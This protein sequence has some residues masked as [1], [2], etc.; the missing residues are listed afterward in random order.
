MKGDNSV[1]GKVR[2]VAEQKFSGIG[3]AVAVAALVATHFTLNNT[4]N[5]ITAM[6]YR[7]AVSLMQQSHI[8]LHVCTL[9]QGIKICPVGL[10]WNKTNAYYQ[11]SIP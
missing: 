11:M 4:Y 1:A 3:T 9:P 5:Q 10:L 6:T 2:F 8:Q 7:S